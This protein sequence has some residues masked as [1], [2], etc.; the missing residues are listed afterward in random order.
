MPTLTAM[1]PRPYVFQ[2]ATAKI[3]LVQA[4]P[5][6]LK[7]FTGYD[8]SEKPLYKLRAGLIY[9]IKSSITGQIEAT[10]RILTEDCNKKDIKDWLDCKMIWVAKETFNN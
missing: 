9:W 10:P 4:L 1:Q 8:K 5:E 7:A 6:D 3:E 2:T